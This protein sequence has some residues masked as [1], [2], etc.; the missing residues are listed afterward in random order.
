MEDL[1]FVAATGE[2]LELESQDGVKYRLILDDSVRRAI[3]TSSSSKSE[4]ASIT[5]REIQ[6]EIRAGASIDE[7]VSRTGADVEYVEKFAAPVLDELAHVVSSALS[8]RITIAGDR[9][10]ESVQVEFGEIISGRL[11]ASGAASEAWS[12]K[13]TEVGSWLVSCDFELNGSAARASWNFDPHRLAL[14]PENELAVQL[15]SQNSLTDGAQPKLRP[16]PAAVSQ[17]TTQ[18]KVVPEASP[19]PAVAPVAAPATAPVAATTGALLTE[20]LGDTSELN[21]VI[22]FGRQH[23]K[24]EP[25]EPATASVEDADGA[26]P[27]LTATA[28]LL[29]ALRQKRLE[30]ENETPQS[31]TDL[32]A[33]PSTAPLRSIPVEVEEPAVEESAS[34]VP[35]GTGFTQEVEPVTPK[36]T[37]SYKKGRT[38]IPSW[39]EI[40]FG[41][42]P[43]EEAEKAD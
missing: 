4:N 5:P 21:E 18:I 29:E 11:H 15:S 9:Y 2:H 35:T 26:E 36:N 43:G 34:Q 30:R 28:D 10:N 23:S 1:R 39:D 38:G 12:A 25:A 24:Q 6:L 16:V 17:A 22:P 27:S 37:V 41:G 20:D 32:D 33:H 14:S 8:V 31:V 3:R 19:A 13:R 42:K 7:I 40:V